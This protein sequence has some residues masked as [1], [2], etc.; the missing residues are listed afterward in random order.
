[1]AF[2][3]QV[4]GTRENEHLIKQ[5]GFKLLETRDTTESAATLSKRWHDARNRRKS[6]LVKDTLFVTRR[7]FP[8]KKRPLPSEMNSNHHSRSSA[9]LTTLAIMVD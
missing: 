1:M 2:V 8:E 4:L 7:K 3:M 5:A 9:L 6:A